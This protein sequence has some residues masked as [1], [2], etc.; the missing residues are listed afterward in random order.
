MTRLT[1]RTLAILLVSICL[2]L[3]IP[4]ASARGLLQNEVVRKTPA[5]IL[6]SAQ[7]I[8][9]RSKT[10]YFKPATLETEL[11]KREEFEQWEMAIARNQSDADL[12]IE[13]DRK[14]F[15]NIFV[16]SV[17]YRHTNM[18]VAG[19]K[20]GSLGGSVEAQIANSFIKRMRRV[21]PFTPKTPEM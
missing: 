20:I 11:L 1:H 18:V 21:R 16:Y 13:V 15:T 5:E 12:I 7:T 8:F 17:I 3:T 2:L 14:L 10:I 9:I 6:Q 19:G 4:S